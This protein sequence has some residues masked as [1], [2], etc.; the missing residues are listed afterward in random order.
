V[1]DVQEYP[2]GLPRHGTQCEGDR[3]AQREQQR[4][5]EVQQQ[6]LDD[7]H[8]KLVVAGGNRWQ[9]RSGQTQ[10]APVAAAVRASGQQWPR[11]RGRATPAP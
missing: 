1:H 3:R 5:Q 7:V 11:K 10:Q 2:A 8:W 9:R 6:V 4:C